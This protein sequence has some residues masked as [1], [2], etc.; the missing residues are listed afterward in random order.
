VN[1]KLEK[2]LATV[3]LALLVGLAL[4]AELLKPGEDPTAGSATSAHPEGRRGLLL[5]LRE[6]GFRADAWHDA[7]GALPRGGGLVWLA[8][9]PEREHAFA[10][11]TPPKP[12]ESTVDDLP[13]VSVEPEPAPALEP[14]EVEAPIPAKPSPAA[15]GM[16][17][18]SHYR[19]FVEQ[20]GT[21][22]VPWSASAK[23][24]LVDEL[25]LAACADVREAPVVPLRKSGPRAFRD[26]RDE[27]LVVDAKKGSVFAPLDAGT[28]I[29]ALWWSENEAGEAAEVLAAMVPAGSGQ[30]VLLGEDSILANGRI[31]EHDHG[32]LAVRLTEEFAR[33][34]R[35]LF[36]EYALGLWRPRTT[37][38][39]LTSPKLLLFTLQIGILLLLALWGAA[40]VREFP[41]DPPPLEGA[42][43]LLRARALASLLVR[44]GRFDVLG[45]A[46]QRGTLRRL[47]RRSPEA[48]ESLRAGADPPA[49]D[50][51]SLERWNR[52]A[53]EIECETS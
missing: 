2:F 48:A 11:T 32:L 6:V 15:H 28:G 50:L 10:L 9:I 27:Q 51:E 18:L 44:A 16:R 49:P 3:M 46:R 22:V 20:G 12:P 19:R 52:R 25:G 45:G 5:L 4:T 42:S 31:G 40:W 47:A 34:S 29:Q 38:T 13:E 14:V 8:A 7:P 33:G 35:V 17:A 41:R 37:T 36:D 1:P 43:P 30:V 53:K 24:F 21:L 39:I 26:A 23:T